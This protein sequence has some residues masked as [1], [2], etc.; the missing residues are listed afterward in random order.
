MHGAILTGATLLGTKLDNASLLG[1][2]LEDANLAGT[3]FKRTFLNG[4]RMPGANLSGARFE[5]SDLGGTNMRRTDLSDAQFLGARLSG[6]NLS[7]AYQLNTR[8]DIALSEKFALKTLTLPTS[9]DGAVLTGGQFFRSDLSGSSL[10]GAD[11]T[12]IVYDEATIWPPG[13]SAPPS[14]PWTILKLDE[15]Q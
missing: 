9:L 10:A 5:L 11:V 14:I 8:Y 12:D 2:D 6:A 1:V 4:A 3:T 15:D 13:F 7:N